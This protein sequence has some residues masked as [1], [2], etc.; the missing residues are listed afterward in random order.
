MS[1]PSESP[2]SQAKA[3]RKPLAALLPVLVF[4]FMAVMFLFALR[5]GEPSKLPSTFIGKLAPALTLDPLEGLVDAGK[6]VP[7]IAPADLARG[8]PVIV[9][10][11]ASWCAPCVGEHPLLIILK[12]KTGVPLIGVNHKDQAP[13]ARRFLGRYGNPFDAV[14]VDGN[15]RAAI[16]WGVYGMPET[17]I[18][19]RSGRILHKHIGALTPEALENVLI[20][21]IE[22]A[23]R[24]ASSVK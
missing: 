21:L 1:S 19:D 18:L 6:P 12:E 7:G 11:W 10:F 8:T 9:N 15:G 13:G 24:T 16:E 4:G 3:A 2:D 22:K 23:K 17:F 20:P 5:S 14:G